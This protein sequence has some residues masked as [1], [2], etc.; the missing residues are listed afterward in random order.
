MRKLMAMKGL[1]ETRGA[2]RDNPHVPPVY[3]ETVEGLYAGTRW[4]RQELEGEMMENVEGALWP[5]ELIEARRLSGPSNPETW[6]RVVVGV[7]PP[8]GSDGDACGIVAVAR[9]RNGHAHV[10]E[11]ASVRGASPEGWARAVAACVARHGADRVV[12][13]KNQ[14]GS[15][16]ESTLRAA[17]ANLPVTLAHASRGKVARAEP[18]SALYEG[19]RAWHAGVFAALEEEMAGLAI[20]GGYSGPGRSP[21]RADAL[22]WAMTELMLG[23][24]GR[25]EVRV[26]RL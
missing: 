11:D 24:V 3:L 12:A 21:D 6:E 9:L 4:G 2:S 7:D 14:G 25:G 18:I 13:E 5:R 20:G 16:V 10:L 17:E 22:V 8:A 26:R 1:V 19:G 23:P 15:M